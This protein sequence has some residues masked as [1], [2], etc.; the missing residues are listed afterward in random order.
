MA[1]ALNRRRAPD[2]IGRA[3]VRHSRKLLAALTERGRLRKLRARIEEPGDRGLLGYRNAANVNQWQRIV[4]NRETDAFLRSL[5]PT[6][7]RAVEV[8]GS[9]YAKHPW[10]EY[11]STDFR[12]FDVCNPPDDLARHDVVICEQVLEHVEDPWRAART[13]HD[14]CEPGGHVVVSTPFMIRVHGTPDDFWRFTE[15]GLCRLL[16]AAGLAVDQVASWGNRAAVRGNLRRFPPLRPWRSLRNDPK[17][18]LVV[19]AFAR[20]LP[21]PA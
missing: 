20:R 8:S 16:E 6:R 13:L 2:G 10:K 4:M 9:G 15:H 7:L 11:T 14:L 3:T 21:D 12:T 18:P 1:D 19:W 17:V 5:G